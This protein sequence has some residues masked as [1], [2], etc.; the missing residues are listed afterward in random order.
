MIKGY[1]L[2][3]TSIFLDSLFKPS[4]FY[5]PIDAFTDEYA[6]KNNCRSD[7]WFIS[8]VEALIGCQSSD[9][10]SKMTFNNRKIALKSSKEHL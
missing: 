1:N 6:C 4:L 8:G 7:F 3:Q 5:L 2:I 9:T 10:L